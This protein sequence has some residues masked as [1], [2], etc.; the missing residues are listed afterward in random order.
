VSLRLRHLFWPALA[1]ALVLSVWVVLARPYQAE[2]TAASN[3]LPAQGIEDLSEPLRLVVLGTSLTANSRWPD[4]LAEELAGCSGRQVQ[5]VRIARAG[6]NSAWGRQEVGAVLAA[7][8]ALVLVEFAIN[9]ADV[10]DGLSLA[11]A[12]QNHL[13]ILGELTV[14]QPGLPVFLM[15]MNRAAGLRGAVRPWLGAHYAQY[16]QI[17]ETAEVGLIDLAPLWASAMAADTAGTLL[18]DGLHPTE[19]AVAQV[20]LPAIAE[21]VGDLVPGCA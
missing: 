10:L 1:L 2:P 13:G 15:T 5:A 19:A 18:P 6:A 14:A 21:L 9:D 3:R 11:Q 7:G 20:A 16:R 4:L 17:A 8:P 12:R